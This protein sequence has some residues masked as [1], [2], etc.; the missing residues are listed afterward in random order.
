MIA[1]WFYRCGGSCQVVVVVRKMGN[2]KDHAEFYIFVAMCRFGKKNV[3]N[4]ELSHCG[5]S[6]IKIQ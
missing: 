6:I 3:F 4:V 5:L 1:N 2:V